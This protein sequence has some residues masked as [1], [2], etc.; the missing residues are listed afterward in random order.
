VD[1]LKDIHH[2]H[3][4]HHQ[5]GELNM[6]EL[7]ESAMESGVLINVSDDAQNIHLDGDLGSA[8]AK[9]LIAA[10]KRDKAAVLSFLTDIRVPTG[11]SQL[12]EILH[13]TG[14]TLSVLSALDAQRGTLPPDAVE[15]LD[16]WLDIKGGAPVPMIDNYESK[17]AIVR[18]PL[19]LPATDELTAE[20]KQQAK[21]KA[22]L[23]AWNAQSKAAA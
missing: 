7:I 21:D 10:I 4:I 13:W 16:R 22:K 8:A 1:G 5:A 11:L 19:N 18:I 15:W 3:H 12:Y 23:A 14:P 2:I 20:Q 9:E 6:K 17:P